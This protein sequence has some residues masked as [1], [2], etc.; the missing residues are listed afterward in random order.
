[1]TQELIKLNTEM[2]LLKLQRK[3]LLDHSDRF[4]P[5]MAAMIREVCDTEYRAIKAM[6]AVLD[7]VKG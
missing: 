3:S 2:M 7:A 4:P 6:Q 5:Y 1:M